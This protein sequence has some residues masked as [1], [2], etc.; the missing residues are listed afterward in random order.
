MLCLSSFQCRRVSAVCAQVRFSFIYNQFPTIYGVQ[1]ESLSSCR[2]CGVK[3]WHLDFQHVHGVWWFYLCVQLYQVYG[4]RTPEDVHAILTALGSHY[5]ILEDSICRAAPRNNCRLPDLIDLDNGVV[6]TGWFSMP[7]QLGLFTVWLCF[8]I[9]C[10]FAYICMCV[11][12]HMY[13]WF[14]T[15]FST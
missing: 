9:V 10:I 12:L 3:Y 14:V 11:C 8:C 5:I 15:L 4:R 1:V 7:L 6:S 2:V 13:V